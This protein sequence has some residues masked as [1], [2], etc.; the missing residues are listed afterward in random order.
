MRK[1]NFLSPLILFLLLICA[2][3]GSLAQ[4]SPE[5][6]R[7]DT[8]ARKVI[9]YMNNNQPDS[10][11]AWTGVHF[12]SQINPALW[13]SIYTGKFSGILPFKEMEFISSKDHVN[14]YKLSGKA[15][16]AFYVSMDEQGKLKD[17]LFQEYREES[18]K[19]AMTPAEKKTDSLALKILSFM[20]KK[21]ADSMYFY[22][23]DSFREKLDWTTFKT[24]VEGSLFPMAPFPSPVFAGSKNGINKY[25]LSQYQF[26]IGLDGKGKY[27]TMALQPYHED[28]VKDEKPLSD[29]P[30]KLTADSIADRVLSKYIRAK[31]N[32]GLSAGLYYKGKEYFYNYG[33]TV[34]GNRQLPSSHTFYEVGSI[35]KT[36]TS[37]LLAM[38][39]NQHKATL[40]TPVAKFLPDSVA[41]NPAL[42]AITL[43][44]LANHTSGLPRLPANF[45]EAVRDL[46]QP[47]EYYDRKRMFSFLK[48]F[49][50]TRKPGEL[51]E[52][53]NF[54]AGLLGVVLERIYNKPYTELIATYIFKPGGLNETKVT[55]NAE[56]QKLSA[57]GYNEQFQPVAAWKFDALVAAGAL[58]STASDLLRYGKLQLHAGNQSLETAFGLTHRVSFKKGT[59][60]LGLGWHYPPNNPDIIQHT[61]GTGGY[62]SFLGIDLKKELVVVVLTNN[63]STGDALGVELLQALENSK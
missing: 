58:K 43:K 18:N 54:G 16:L 12:K 32:I 8:L 37:T 46:Q 41:A 11:Y 20:N 39:V 35:T 1:R 5:E 53:S 56:E 3:S 23:G 15:A 24:V 36:F 4:T 51:Y 27:S 61:G 30:M 34:S 9:G 47:Y 6:K 59:N 19:T 38:A 63:A 25:K 50:P 13:N 26:I 33:E 21:Q 2:G 42:R 44:D 52:Y 28:A 31:G 62:R 49:Q 17:F 14:K 57:Q 60:I 55:L 45:N 10:V 40:E 7:T 48:H 22:A 29:N